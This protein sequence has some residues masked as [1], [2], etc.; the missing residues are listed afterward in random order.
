[1][2]PQGIIVTILAMIYVLF[3]NVSDVFLALIGM[4][5]ALYVVM[6]MLMFA[7]AVVLRK[8]E[9]NI[10]RGYKVPALLLVSGIGFISCALSFVMSFLPAEGESSIPQNIYPL[11]VAVVV[12]LLGI[13]PF[14]FYI[15]KK[16]SW[17]Q[18][19]KASS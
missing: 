10:N 15:L 13:P 5:A 16:P 8:K 17:D 19:T 4:A 18:R 3:P 7:A 1:M 14:I 11:I 6:Y 12:I 9:P 2:I